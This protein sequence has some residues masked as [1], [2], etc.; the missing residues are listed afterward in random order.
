LIVV[1]ASVALAWFLEHNRSALPA[2]RHVEEL[3]GF[4]PGNFHSELV[5]GFLSAER[6]RRIDL[7]AAERSLNAVLQLSLEVRSPDPARVL[8]VARDHQLTGYDAA[9]LTLAME[10]GLPLATADASLRRAAK[11]T[12]LL[13]E[14]E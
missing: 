9:Y 12:N 1:D 10:L 11:A 2:L 14:P 8:T 7:A 6:Q 5:H 4:V 13:W 3:G